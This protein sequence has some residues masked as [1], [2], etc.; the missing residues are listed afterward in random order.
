MAARP[1]CVLIDGLIRA[2]TVVTTAVVAYRVVSLN[3]SDT[4]C[5][6]TAAA[7][8][9]DGVALE[10]G[11]V[12]AVI[13]VVLLAGA[14]IVPVLVGTGGATRGMQAVVVADGVTNSG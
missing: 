8:A 6:H 5:V 13:P 1:D 12:G 7:A 3:T 9:G 14:A 11:A 4:Q 10:A 2:K